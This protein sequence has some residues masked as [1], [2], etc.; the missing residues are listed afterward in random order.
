MPGYRYARRRVLPRVRANRSALSLVKRVFSI[1]GTQ[2]TPMD[3]TAG[4]L[5]GGVG[6]ERLPVVVVIMIGTPAAQVPSIVDDVA[7][8]Q[9]LTA[10][11]RPV[12][13]MDTPALAA[14]RAYGYPVEL[15]IDRDAW[16]APDQSWDDYVSRRLWSV[17]RTYR[18]TA[19]VTADSGAL[20]DR[21][22]MILRSLAAL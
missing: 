8:T 12:F 11:F 21:S 17:Y 10:G 18:P 2:S 15:L 13:V 4:N 7:R 20:T 1:D 6:A 14:P 3:V 5:L 22:R 16:F 9:V 19:T